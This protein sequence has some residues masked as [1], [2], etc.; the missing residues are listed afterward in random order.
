[1]PASTFRT[2]G[3]THQPA[4]PMHAHVVVGRQGVGSGTDDDHRVVEDVVGQVAADLGEIFDPTDLLPHPAPQLV[5]LGA[6]I[7]LRDIGLYRDGD[8]LAELLRRH[9]AVGGPVVG[10]S[11]SHFL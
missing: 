2:V 3:D 5:P 7:V 8:G 10:H 11:V 1:M 9:R 6:Q 4:A